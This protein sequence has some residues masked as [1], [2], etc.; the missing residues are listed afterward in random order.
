MTLGHWVS[1]II[2]HWIIA[3]KVVHFLREN[4]EDSSFWRY[5][6][7]CFSFI[8]ASSCNAL[9]GCELWNFIRYDCN[10]YG[11]LGEF[12]VWD[13]DYE[14]GSYSGTKNCTFSD[15]VNFQKWNRNIEESK[16]VV[17]RFMC[18]IPNCQIAK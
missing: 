16:I 8:L 11:Y 14:S 4:E 17:C 15:S 5:L 1:W 10:L 2:K 13:Q 18:K 7:V 6:N 12:L 3:Y 9:D